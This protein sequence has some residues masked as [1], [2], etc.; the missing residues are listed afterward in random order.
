MF[1]VVV[2]LGSDR[3]TGLPRC[4]KDNLIL[5][6][7]VRNSSQLRYRYLHERQTP[8]PVLY[9]CTYGTGGTCEDTEAQ[10]RA[11]VLGFLG[12]NPTFSSWGFEPSQLSCETCGL[13][14]SQSDDN[15]KLL[16]QFSFGTKKLD[17][18]NWNLDIVLILTF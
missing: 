18:L 6:N 14:L 7:F 11:E 15:N 16:T 12:L 3:R 5:V 10:Q 2:A 1:L 8:V 17:R 9:V 4:M 13:L